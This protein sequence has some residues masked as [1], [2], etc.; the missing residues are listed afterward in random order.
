MKRLAGRRLPQFAFAGGGLVLFGDRVV[1]AVPL[2]LLVN[3][4]QR[5]RTDQH[6]DQQREETDERR[7]NQDR[8][9]AV[10]VVQPEAQRARETGQ[11]ETGCNDTSGDGLHSVAAATGES[12]TGGHGNV[13]PASVPA[14]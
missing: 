14:T 12:K 13:G 4:A 10:A 5:D 1:G 8:L 3:T 6:A 2:D 11:R 9:P 7:V